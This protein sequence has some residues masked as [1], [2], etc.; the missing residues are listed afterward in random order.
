MSEEAE[1]QPTKMKQPSERDVELLAAS[2]AWTGPNLTDLQKDGFR[3]RA[4]T[5]FL[6][7][8]GGAP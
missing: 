1:D 4:R 7:M 3:K 5:M 6:I 8:F 2:I